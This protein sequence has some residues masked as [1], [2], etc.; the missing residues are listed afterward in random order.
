MSIKIEFLN[1]KSKLVP[2]DYINI[3]KISRFKRLRSFLGLSTIE[4]TSYQIVC[5]NG[6][7]V[8][9]VR[10]VNEDYYA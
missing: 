1:I 3:S 7:H 5:F 2:D 4:T 6:P 10:N 8:A 9:V